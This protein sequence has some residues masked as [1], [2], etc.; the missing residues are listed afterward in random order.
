MFICPENSALKETSIYNFIL[1]AR[2]TDRNFRKTT[3]TYVN[4]SNVSSTR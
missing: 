3:P 2:Y 4:T 1:S